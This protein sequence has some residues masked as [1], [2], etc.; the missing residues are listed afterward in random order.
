MEFRT[1]D[2]HLVPSEALRRVTGEGAQYN[3][4]GHMGYTAPVHKPLVSGTRVGENALIYYTQGAG[5]IVHKTSPVYQEMQKAL[6]L[7]IKK[8][9]DQKLTPLYEHKGTVNFDYYMATPCLKRDAASATPSP[10]RA[11]GAGEGARGGA[12]QRGARRSV[13]PSYK[14]AGPG[15]QARALGPMNPGTP[16]EV[17]GPNLAASPAAIPGRDDLPPPFP[18]QPMSV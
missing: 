7:A 12:D 18:R 14:G 5:Y 9:G 10:E 8:H 16:I 3:K 6:K 13:A 1:A 17:F 4:L 2:G 11:P 15:N